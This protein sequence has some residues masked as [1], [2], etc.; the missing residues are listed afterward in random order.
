[1]KTYQFIILIVILIVILVSFGFRLLNIVNTNLQSIKNKINS[2]NVVEKFE[3]KKTYKDA[4]LNADVIMPPIKK[5][6]ARPDQYPDE[7]IPLIK[8]VPGDDMEY[9]ELDQIYINPFYSEDDVKIKPNQNYPNPDDMSSVERNAFKFGYPNGMTMQDYVNWLYLYRLTP[10]LL[11]LE[12][13]INY[14][15]LIK[16]VKIE[17]EK[18]RVPPP[19]KR[20][21]PLNGEDYFLNMYTQNPTQLDPMFTQT[22]NAE[23]RVAGNLGS[24][25]NGMLPYNY[26]EYPDFSQNFNVMGNSQNIYNNELAFKTDPY[27]LQKFVGPVSLVKEPKLSDK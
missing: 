19:A 8:P 25:T 24:P 9:L 16:N 4:A 14:Q 18:D 11:S 3:E 6:N 23:I 5:T 22:R 26:S 21:P 10:E 27:F 2:K 20:M 7:D 17:Y 15:K 13:N 1:M 12:H